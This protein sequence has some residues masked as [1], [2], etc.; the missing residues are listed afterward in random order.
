VELADLTRSMRKKMEHENVFFAKPGFSEFHESSAEKTFFLEP[1]IIFFCKAQACLSF[2]RAAWN[3][4]E[5]VKNC[6]FAKP[7]FSEFHK[8]SA[9]KAIFQSVKK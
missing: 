9:E 5:S 2:I 1:E 4:H 3:K 8:S 7:G 6:F